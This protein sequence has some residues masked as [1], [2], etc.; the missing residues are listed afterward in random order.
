[1]NEE[2]KT[3]LVVDDEP[4]IVK[5]IVSALE[6][7]GYKSLSA[8]N[9]EQALQV[10]DEAII[11][12]SA[13][14][15]DVKMPNMD[16]Y[17]LCE[18]IRKSED[19]KDIPFIFASS[20]STLDEKI[21]GYNAGADDYVTKPIDP[22][23]LLLK[24]ESLIKQKKIKDELNKQLA[25][26]KGVAMEALNYTSSL[27]RVVNF[28]EEALLASSFDDL[29]QKLFSIT[30]TYG[31]NCILCII[32]GDEL[33]YISS[34]DYV[35][36]LEKNVIDL[37]RQ[38]SRF[39]HF[40]ARTIINYENHSLLVKN[41]PKEDENK[42]GM[43]NDMLGALCNAIY[44]KLKIFI[45]EINEAKKKE[46]ILSVLRDAID[47]I[48]SEFKNLQ[49]KSIAIIEDMREQVDEAIMGMGLLE[50][51]EKNLEKVVAECLDR[52]NKNFYE[53]L[54]LNDI[55]NELREEI[56]TCLASKEVPEV[57]LK[58]DALKIQSSS[59]PELF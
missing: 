6:K 57:A 5:Q 41:M 25:E 47:K 36:P 34:R 1:M 22:E 9:G 59:A 20:L 33:M 23:D 45:N 2:A 4:I 13:I 14:I 12:I 54:R 32:H 10:L 55:F 52:S 24:V 43:L 49:S 18:L 53:G 51:T 3:I 46:S 50:D 15:S 26:S 17:Y 38:Q 29:A 42:Y 37:A 35:S 44:A 7:K 48:D 30:G 39:F 31:L 27:G 8:V 21:R 28:Y 11:D 19:C 40:G 58:D 56:D 16:G